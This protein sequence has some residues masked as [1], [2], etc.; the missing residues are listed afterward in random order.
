MIDNRFR[1]ILVTGGAGFIGSAVVRLLLQETG[2]G[3]INLDKLTYAGDLRNVAPVAA[4]PAYAFEQVD[5]CDADALRTVFQRHQPDLVLHLAAESHVDRSIAGAGAF[6]QTNVNGT[7]C[8]LEAALEHFRNLTPEGQQV[9]RL[10]H[11]STDEVFGT[12]GETGAFN[13]GTPYAPNSPYSAT[14]AA[15]DHLVRAWFHTFGLPSLITNCSNNYGPYQFP[16]KLIPLMITN[17]LDGLPLPVYGRGTNVRDWLF[18]EDHARAII[19]IANQGVPGESY[20]IGGHNEWR[21]IDIVKSICTLLD[22]LRPRSDGA[23]YETQIS[24]VTDRAGHDFRYAINPEKL[25]TELGL[26]VATGFESGLR[27]TVQWY[28]DN[29][30]WWRPL[31]NRRSA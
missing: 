17:A 27:Q 25:E 30:S 11:V 1:K 16:E 7:F 22:Q 3:V 6:V 5:I 14:K 21:N 20:C 29:E 15:S 18:V 8:L 2:A 10:L 24:F 12:L 4:S 19:H 28:L 9:F 31:L 13:E 26:K 23:P